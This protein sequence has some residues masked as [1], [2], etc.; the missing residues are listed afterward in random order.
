MRFT[1]DGREV[2]AREGESI[3]R[4]AQ[5]HVDI[6]HLC[7]KDGLRA[8][9]NCRACVVEIDGERAPALVLP[10]RAESGHAGA[11]AERARR[12]GAEDGAGTAAVGHAG[13]GGARGFRTRG[14]GQPHGCWRAAL[15][16][17]R[18]A[19]GG[20]LASGHRRESCRLHPMHALPARLQGSA[21]Q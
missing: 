1:L 7:W 5:R 16:A 11:G 4:A 12:G 15:P 21:G 17:P 3:L 10:P 19:G 8:D 20:C 2:D 13:R 18:A 14:L 6:P 9:G